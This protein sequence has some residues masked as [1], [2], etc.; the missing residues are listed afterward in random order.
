MADE[1]ALLGLALETV[2]LQTVAKSQDHSI[3]HD[4]DYK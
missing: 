1:A 3:D 4:T 2:A